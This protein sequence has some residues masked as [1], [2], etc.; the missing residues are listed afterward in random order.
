MPTDD[1]FEKYELNNLPDDKLLSND[2]LR[3]L[4][5]H[6]V[7]KRLYKRDLIDG[8]VLTNVNRLN[9]TISRNSGSVLRVN[10]AN[11]VES[12]VFVYNLGT[13]YFIDDVLFPEKR[14]HG[15][16]DAD[17]VTAEAGEKPI[18]SFN[19][20]D[21][22]SDEFT[23]EISSFGGRHELEA[24]NIDDKRPQPA[25]KFLSDLLKETEDVEFIDIEADQRQQ[26]LRNID[27]PK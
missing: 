14:S 7:A 6:F 24:L 17:D 10:Q 21:E 4:L 15:Q 16:G 1:A 5:N 11:I 20:N 27:I 9:L 2:T 25:G 23:T 3:I 22:A 26:A 8:S 19:D 18:S 13:M 12:E